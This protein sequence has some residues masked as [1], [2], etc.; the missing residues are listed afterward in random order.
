MKPAL[1]YFAHIIIYIPI[2]FTGGEFPD[3]KQRQKMPVAVAIAISV[4]SLLLIA[5]FI[6]FVVQAF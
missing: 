1:R 3:A 6:Y 2:L 4:I 5:A